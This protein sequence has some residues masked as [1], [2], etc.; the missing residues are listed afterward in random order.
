MLA[1]KIIKKPSWQIRMHQL[2]KAMTVM[3]KTPTSLASKF[4]TKKSNFNISKIL[5]I[6]LCVSVDVI[7]DG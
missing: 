2:V 3:K 6:F 1:N 5:C 4:I 7:N